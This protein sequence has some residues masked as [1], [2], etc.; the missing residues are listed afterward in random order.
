MK[1]SQRI[2]IVEDEWLTARSLQ[3]DMEDLGIQVVGIAACGEDAV[4]IGLKEIPDFIL[5]DIRLAGNMDGI[6]A[7]RL[8][9]QQIKI[10]IIFMTG[11]ATGDVKKRALSV[12]RAAFLEKP[13]N[14]DMIR[15]IRNEFS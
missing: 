2:L 1:K 9:H 15:Q 8:I 6:E 13:V 4:K 14:P 11:Y 7:A 5:M 12:H 3:M 10:P